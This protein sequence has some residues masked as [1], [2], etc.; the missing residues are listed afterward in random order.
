MGINSE[1]S[2][3]YAE[4][5]NARGG[6]AVRDVAWSATGFVL[7]SV[8]GN[9]IGHTSAHASETLSWKSSEPQLEL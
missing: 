6:G 2:E 9:V 4:I 1:P 7:P 3:Q 8:V 5:C